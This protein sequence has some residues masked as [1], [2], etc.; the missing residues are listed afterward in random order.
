MK[1]S[2]SF[3]DK[4]TVIPAYRFAL[5]RTGQ[6]VESVGLQKTIRPLLPSPLVEYERVLSQEASLAVFVNST[7]VQHDKV[8][9]VPDP[10]VVSAPVFISNVLSP[11]PPSVLPS[12]ETSAFAPVNSYND[13]ADTH[14]IK[15][16]LLLESEFSQSEMDSFLNDLDDDLFKPL[17]DDLTMEQWGALFFM[18]EPVVQN[19]FCKVEGLGFIYTEAFVAVPVTLNGH[20][21][22]RVSGAFPSC[23]QFATPVHVRV[24]KV[25]QVDEWLMACYVAC[26]LYWHLRK[27]FRE[28]TF[29]SWLSLT[30][31]EF[32]VFTMFSRRKKLNMALQKDAEFYAKEIFVQFNKIKS[33]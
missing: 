30:Y 16:V 15:D 8:V 12:S 25:Q 31:Q 7:D 10:V 33:F 29:S 14:P 1:L 32:D 24:R 26:L 3:F 19:M 22:L 11:M 9:P 23:C 20:M 2:W 5:C 13:S 18:K 27:L 21:Y 6:N 28:T 4:K 17:E